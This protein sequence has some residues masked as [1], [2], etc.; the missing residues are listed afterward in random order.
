MLFKKKNK[1]LRNS[2][3][4]YESFDSYMEQLQGYQ[5]DKIKKRKNINIFPSDHR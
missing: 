3:R 5:K 1:K 2:G 4:I